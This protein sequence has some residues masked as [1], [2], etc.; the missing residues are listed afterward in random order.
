ME[1]AIERKFI[2]ISSPAIL[3]ELQEKLRVKFNAP[4]EKAWDYLLFLLKLAHVVEPKK[5]P[6]IVEE[7][8]SYNKIIAAATEGKADFMRQAENTAIGRL[9]ARS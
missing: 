7:D 2:L 6:K 1:K 3:S 8:P 5:E 4:D 9:C